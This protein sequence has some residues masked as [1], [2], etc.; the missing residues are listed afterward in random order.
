MRSARV[1]R[2]ISNG[3]A[4]PSSASRTYRLLST[5]SFAMACGRASNRG[6]SALGRD[7]VAGTGSAPGRAESE[8]TGSTDGLE[9]RAALHGDDPKRRYA[10]SPDGVCQYTAIGDGRGTCQKRC[11]RQQDTAGTLCSGHDEGYLSFA[12]RRADQND[13]HREAMIPI[14]KSM[15]CPRPST[16]IRTA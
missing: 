7:A 9:K 12:T 11:H 8:G 16:L 10:A 5:P 1:P 2:P 14:V 4:A 15:I 3:Y 6:F 13:S